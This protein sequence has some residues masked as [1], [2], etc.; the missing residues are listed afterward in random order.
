M[1]ATHWRLGFG[2]LGICLAL[3]ARAEGQVAIGGDR[4]Y[5]LGASV[6]SANGHIGSGVTRYDIKP[7]WAFQLGPFRVSRSRANSLMRA[8]REQ[9]ETGV[10][11]EFDVFSDW[12]LGASLRLDNGR[13]FDGDPE[14]SGLPDVRSTLRGRVSTGRSFGERWNW[15]L[16]LDQDLLGRGGGARLNTGVNYR[17]P[18]SQRTNLDFSLGGGWGDARYQRTIYGISTE[19]AQATGREPYRLGS[20]WETLRVGAHFETALSTHWVVFG[21]LDLSRVLGSTARSPL[22]GRLVTHGL[23]VGVAY[24]SK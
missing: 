14:F 10:S 12:R 11:A 19:A 8:G 24:R 6:V 5:L 15:S 17:Y 7:L 18:V 20:G 21:G 16:S 3:Q 1:S 9:L 2:I 22:V 13:S 23:G 4:G